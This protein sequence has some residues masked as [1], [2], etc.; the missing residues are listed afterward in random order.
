MGDELALMYDMYTQ[1][2]SLEKT[3]SSLMG[4]CQ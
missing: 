4:H 3:N 2:T 1:E